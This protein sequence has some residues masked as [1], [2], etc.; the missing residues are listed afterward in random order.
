MHYCNVIR[1]CK[2]IIV[3]TPQIQTYPAEVSADPTARELENK[4]LKYD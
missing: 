4:T 3:K 1:L 2:N